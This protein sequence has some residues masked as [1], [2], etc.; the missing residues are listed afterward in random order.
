MSENNYTKRVKLTEQISLPP[1]SSICSILLGGI[2]ALVSTAS[3]IIDVI[4]TQNLIAI[5]LDLVVMAVSYLTV[6]QGLYFSIATRIA[7][8]R[9]EEQWN[10]KI[11]PL[12]NLIEETAGKVDAIERNVATSNAKLNTMTDYIL[13]ARDMDASKAYIIPGMSFKFISKILVLIFFTFASLVYVSSYPLGMVH[14]FIMV[15]YLV[16]WLF[17]TIEYKLFGSL[18]TWVYAAVPVLIIPSV[19]IIMSAI[20]GLNIM[21]GILFLALFIYIYMYYTWASYTVSGYS[22]ID[23]NQ[24]V[25]QIKERLKRKKLHDDISSEELCNMIRGK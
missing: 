5:G 4:S 25:Q 8:E 9:M 7:K 20:Y 6:W 14:Y 2:I 19:G 11:D 15:I 23:T 22:L 10:T 18:I 21:I 1:I 17:I 24:I 12:I 13:Q 3:F 16:W